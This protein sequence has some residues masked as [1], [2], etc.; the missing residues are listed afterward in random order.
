MAGTCL[1]QANEL[2]VDTRE[3]N[4]TVTMIPFYYCLI[5]WFCRHDTID[6]GC[7]GHRV[8]V[9]ARGPSPLLNYKITRNPL[10]LIEN[11]VKLEIPEY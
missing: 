7:T 9:T 11:F 1:T 10:D 3:K 8:K 6:A 2:A 5:L 4:K